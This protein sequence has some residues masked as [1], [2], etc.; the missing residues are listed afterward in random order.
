[1]RGDMKFTVRDAKT[2]AIKKVYLYKNLVVTVGRQNIAQRIASTNTNTLNVNYGAVGTG[3]NTP[4]NADTTLQ[5]ETFRKA[6]S[7]NS[8][9]ANQAFLSFFYSASEAV[10]TLKEFGSFIDATG[11]ADSGVM[12]SRVAINVV[13][14]SSDTLT[15]DVTYTI[16]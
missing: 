7:S 9:T 16:S 2:D 11:S 13:K 5:T 10:A 14:T 12:L 1:M 15:I 3:T 6:I 4:A 8:S